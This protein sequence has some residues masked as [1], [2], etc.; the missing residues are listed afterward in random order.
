MKITEAKWNF[1]LGDSDEFVTIG[2]RNY[3]YWKI[4]G[5]LTLQYQEG[6]IPKK[7]DM[8]GSK[9]EKFTTC[10]FVVPTLEQLSVYLL[11][12][13]N[14]GYAWVSDC[15]CNQFMYNVKL[16]DQGIRSFYTSKSKIIVEGT[17]DTVVHCWP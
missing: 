1:Y 5:N 9:D 4:S 8:F 3:H 11:I 7:R 6:D 15:R 16:L 13:T 14:N 17:K 10:E 12:G 2:E